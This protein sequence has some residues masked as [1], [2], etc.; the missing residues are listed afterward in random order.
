MLG[1]KRIELDKNDDIIV[2]G[3]KYPETLYELIF[4]EFP[5][6]TICTNADKQKSILLATNAH[7]RG[8]S[9]HNAI[10]GNEG[11]KYKNIIALLLSSKRV[12]R[13]I[14]RTVTLNYNKIDS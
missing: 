4:K 5:D 14:P 2:D 3:K 6:E 8:Y 12:D 9:T 10:M 13:G 1:N 11:H 7:R